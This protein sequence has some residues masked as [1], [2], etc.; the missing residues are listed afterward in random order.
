MSLRKL[1]EIQAFTAPQAWSFD[2]PD[3]LEAAYRAEI[4]TAATDTAIN[5]FGAVGVDGDTAVD[6]GPRRI[7]AALRAIGAQAVTVNLNS[8]GGNYFDGLA[9]YNALRQ[10]PAE[11]TVNVLGLA[12]SAASVIAMAGDKIMIGEQASIM[13]HCAAGL[14]AGNKYD[15]DEI[16][17]LLDQVDKAMAT[18]YSAR[19]GVPMEK[20]LS[21]VE[22]RQ[23]AGTW[24]S[25]QA[26]IDAGLADAI[27]TGEPVTADAPLPEALPERVMER[28]LM[29]QLGVSPKEAKAM[30]SQIKAGSRDAPAKTTTR[31][32]G[33]DVQTALA[34]LLLTIRGKTS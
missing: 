24:F 23:G 9:I 12:G 27:V 2:L 22:A 19:A 20:A 6:N 17:P 4:V 5:I 8:P 10:H 16:R 13:V 11:V 1:P 34:D 14:V 29:A 18:I 21:W 31:D 7:M 25:G 30:I 15:M 3:E 28:A 26:A 33:S 32:A